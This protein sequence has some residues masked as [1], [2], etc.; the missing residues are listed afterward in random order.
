M[1]VVA[2]GVLLEFRLNAKREEAILFKKHLERGER[3]ERERSGIGER[4]KRGERGRERKRKR[5][6][7]EREKKMVQENSG[8]R[9]NADWKPNLETRIQHFLVLFSSIFGFPPSLALFFYFSLPQIFPSLRDPFSRML[10]GTRQTMMNF[11]RRPATR[12]AFS[13][14]TRTRTALAPPLFLGQHQRWSSSTTSSTTTLPPFSIVDSTLR[15]GEQFATCEF[16]REDRVY[17]AKM[18]DRMGV[19]YIEVQNPA[20]GPGAVEDIKKLASLR[21]K[22]AKLLAH[23][24]CHMDDVRIAVDSGVHGLNVYMATSQAL[25]KHSHGKS[26]EQVLEAAKEVSNKIFFYFFLLFKTFSQS[27]N[28]H[29]CFFNFCCCRSSAMSNNTILKFDFH[30]KMLFE[31]TLTIFSMFIKK[32]D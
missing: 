10:I 18:L 8:R 1:S 23:T 7:K 15:E 20:A 21:L 32:L 5:K 25:T 28:N 4:K 9:K 27:L 29:F 3:E 30:V 2:S 26:I 17:I 16:T 11:L 14:T 24:R 13:T 6:K 19:E 31:A 22:N 12:S